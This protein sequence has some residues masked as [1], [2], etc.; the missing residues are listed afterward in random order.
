VRFIPLRNAPLSP[1]S[2]AF[3]P[4]VREPLLRS[5]VEAALAAVALSE[6]EAAP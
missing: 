5:F 2:L 6:N 4:G 1:V 3:R